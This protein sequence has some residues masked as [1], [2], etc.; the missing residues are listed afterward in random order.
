M[1]GNLLSCKLYNPSVAVTKST[2]NLIAMTAMDTTNL[3]NVFIVPAHGMVG[4]VLRG[5]LTGAITY[6]SILLGVM[7][8]ATVVGCV[9]PIQTLGNT[10]VA[11]ALV[12]VEAVFI[13]TGLTPGS[14]TWDAAYAVKTIVA[15]SGIRYGGP[16]DAIANSA[17]GG[18]TFSVY[19]PQPQATTAQIAVNSVGQ[20][21]IVD[22]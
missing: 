17:F 15:A 16:N 11:T 13:I 10:A 1:F 7:N 8:G 20:V 9:A 12:N 5:V 3:R 14:V 21:S 19:D 6:P 18:F 22:R 4:V 2:A